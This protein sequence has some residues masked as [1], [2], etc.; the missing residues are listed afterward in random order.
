M[1][2]DQI[3]NEPEGASASSP[4][5]PQGG[6][7]LIPVFSRSLPQKQAGESDRDWA[8]RAVQSLRGGTKTP[9]RPQRS[10]MRLT[11]QRIV[12][13][14]EMLAQI[15]EHQKQTEGEEDS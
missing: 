5:Q 1:N 3:P 4:Q 2:K 9:P 12:S 7:N 8:K 15:R 10:G 13:Y 14:E 11:G 6:G